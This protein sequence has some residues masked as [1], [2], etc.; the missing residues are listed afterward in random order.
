M[1]RELELGETW[2]LLTHPEAGLKESDAT[3]EVVESYR[4]KGITVIKIPDN[5]TDHQGNVYQ[6]KEGKKLKKTKD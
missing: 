5:D 2:V 1:P 6:I 4:K 3:D